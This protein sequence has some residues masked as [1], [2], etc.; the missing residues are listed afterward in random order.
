MNRNRKRACP[1]TAERLGDPAAF[2]ELENLM[3]E[4]LVILGL[5]GTLL[6]VGFVKLILGLLL[7]PVKIIG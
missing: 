7:L 3:F 4:I 2:F 5:A 1:V 6:A